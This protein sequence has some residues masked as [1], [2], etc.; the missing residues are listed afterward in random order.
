MTIKAKAQIG[1]DG[2]I[3]LDASARPGVAPGERDVTVIIEEA[4][5]PVETD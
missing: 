2:R 3:T 4:R 5:P 1:A